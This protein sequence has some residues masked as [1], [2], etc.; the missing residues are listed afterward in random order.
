MRV[1]RRC[2]RA[3]RGRGPPTSTC[4]RPRTAQGLDPARLG[5]V[6][7]DDGGD[8]WRQAPSG[9]ARAPSRCPRAR[10]ARSRVRAQRAT[11]STSPTAARAR[12]WQRAAWPRTRSRSSRSPIPCE[13]RRSSSRRCR[14]PRRRSRPRP[15]P[16][17]TGRQHGSAMPVSA[18]SPPARP[19]WCGVP[20][21]YRASESSRNPSAERHHDHG[22]GD[23]PP[24]SSGSAQ[25]DSEHPRLRPMTGG[26]VRQS[27]RARAGR[28][29]PGRAPA[30][31]PPPGGS[32]RE[33]TSPIGC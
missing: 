33:P 8:G 12:P 11:P 30:R 13:V 17:G 21:W 5:R 19:R 14:A 29:P 10:E 24:R 31:A 15:R 23:R 32:Q 16:Q 27:G 18:S 26:R 7:S 28:F 4:P 3:P 2:G 6:A 9:I 20:R 1:A 25:R 22:L